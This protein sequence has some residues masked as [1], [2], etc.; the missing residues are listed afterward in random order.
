MTHFSDF[1]N[2]LKMGFVLGT[3]DRSDY[4]KLTNPASLT[5]LILDT[6]SIFRQRYNE[7]DQ[8]GISVHGLQKL[9]IYD[10]FGYFILYADET[11]AVVLANTTCGLRAVEVIFY[12]P[13]GFRLPPQSMIAS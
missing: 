3:R 11:R 9:C 5:E 10:D 7:A 8:E 2:L 12:C 1:K 6:R 13:T 4:E